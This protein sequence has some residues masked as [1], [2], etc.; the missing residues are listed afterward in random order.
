M[1]EGEDGRRNRHRSAPE[2]EAWTLLR[3]RLFAYADVGLSRRRE[4]QQHPERSR[5]L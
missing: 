2:R 5:L 1:Q 3:H 4:G